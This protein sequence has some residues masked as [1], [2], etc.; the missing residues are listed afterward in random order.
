TFSSEKQLADTAYG[1]GQVLMSAID[2]AWFYSAIANEGIL[3]EVSL[4]KEKET[5]ENPETVQ[6]ISAE[7]AGTAKKYLK[8]VETDPKGTAHSLA[9]LSLPLA[10]KTGTAEF[11]RAEKEGNDTNGFLMAFDADQT[12]FLLVSMIEDGSGGDAVKASKPYLKQLY[13]EIRQ[14]E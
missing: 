7:A 8:E 1:Q 2:Q 9:D 5:G 12:R 11:K 3:P 6:V 14:P 13:E 4:L 10:A